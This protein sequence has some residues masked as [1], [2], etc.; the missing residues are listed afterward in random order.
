[1]FA[2]EPLAVLY[3]WPKV[4]AHLSAFSAPLESYHALSWGSVADSSISWLMTDAIASA[5]A[6]PLGP[7]VCSE[8]APIFA[9]GSPIKAYL[10]IVPL[11]LPYVCHPQYLLRN[12]LVSS[13]YGAVST[14]YTPL[15]STG[16]LPAAKALFTRVQI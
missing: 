7:V 3:V 6:S 9:M 1:M 5:A 10:I 8:H 2:I 16:S 14:K 11:K 4:H 12:P 15:A 13:T